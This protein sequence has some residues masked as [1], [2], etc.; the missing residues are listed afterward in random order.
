[1][2]RDE[3]QLQWGDGVPGA[4]LTDDDRAAIAALLADGLSFAEIARRLGR[5]TSTITREVARNGGAAGYRADTAAAATHRRA[6]RLAGGVVRPAAVRAFEDRFASTMAHTGLPPTPARVLAALLATD[7]AS[8]SAAELVR[9]LEI[10]PASVSKAVGYLTELALIRRERDPGDRRARYV[11]DDDAWYRACLREVEVC[12]TWSG[13]ARQGAE[14]LGDSPAGT[15]LDRLSRYFDH[16]GR[17]LAASA[18]R[19]RGMP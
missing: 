19:W 3:S 15:R 18:E 1:V 13:A 12:A 2:A 7:D 9:R 10:S 14:V 4:R 17:D 11:V 5:P 8:L 6:S 16:V